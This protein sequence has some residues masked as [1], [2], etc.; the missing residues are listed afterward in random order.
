MSASLS[1][2]GPIN[3]KH[4]AHPKPAPAP[5]VSPPAGHPRHLADHFVE[6]CHLGRY[7]TVADNHRFIITDDFNT[8]RFPKDAAAMAA[9]FSKDKLVAQAAVLPLGAR[10]SRLKGK[11]RDRYEELFTL[12]EAQALDD[13]V[14]NSARSLMERGFREVEIQA[15]EASL[16]DQMSPARKRYRDFLDVVRQLMD[17][18]MAA[19]NFLEEFQ[20][21]TSDVAGRLDFGIYSFCLDR[22]FGSTRIPVMVKQLLVGELL[23]FPPLVRRELITNVLA[24]PGQS[25]DL[26]RYVRET[27]MSELGRSVAVEIELLEA[28]KTRRLTLRDL[29]GAFAGGVA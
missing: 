25:G 5:G 10:A 7:L 9:M 11:N 20:A 18:R 1:P 16:G 21:F 8:S 6:C 4:A 2:N 22:L 12:I 19:R 28:Y 3:G 24:Y 23:K 27:V 15:L 13:R 26:R 17:G 29:A 14:R